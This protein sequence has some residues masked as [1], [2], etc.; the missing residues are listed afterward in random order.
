[1]TAV[2]D[3]AAAHDFARRLDFTTLQLFVAVGEAGSIGRAAAREALA[4][5]AV[6][7]R[8][9]ELEALAGVPLL[10]RHARGVALTPAG[11]SL[12]RHAQEAL[13]GLEK[14]QAALGEYASGARGP[15]R[16]HASISAVVQ[17]LPDDLGRFV[18]ENADVKIELQEHLSADV[19]RAVQEGA[20]DVGICNASAL[21]PA[22]GRA[23]PLQSRPYRQD[24][25]LLAVPQGHPLAGRDE[26]A[27]ADTLAFDHVGLQAGSSI[28]QAMQQAARRAGRPVRLRVRVTGLAAMCRMIDNG[29]GVGLM[30]GRAFALLR[31][32]GQG[33]LL[34]VPLADAWAL[35]QIALIARDFDSLPAPARALVA[36]LA[37]DAPPA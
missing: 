11:Q 37:A 30:P 21:P 36:H 6:S 7:K 15:V 34:G 2:P 23:A 25:L 1:M 32:V 9:A 17:F 26:V 5:S 14:M 13:F 29:L 3:S 19:V 24:R 20:A 35:R 18:R 4:A 31:G 8:L 33:R 12:L 16:V 22:P 28:S 10:L 27:F